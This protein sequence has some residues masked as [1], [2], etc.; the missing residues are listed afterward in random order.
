MTSLGRLSCWQKARQGHTVQEILTDGSFKNQFFA[1]LFVLMSTIN[2]QIY[3]IHQDSKYAY[4][5]IIPV[6]FGSVFMSEPFRLR[7]MT[8]M[9]HSRTT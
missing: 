4:N 8:R 6:I 1:A 5:V 7:H 9:T 2:N 3:E